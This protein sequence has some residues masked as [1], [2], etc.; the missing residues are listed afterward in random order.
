[1][2]RKLW[3]EIVERTR[4][5][6]FP[7]L[8][9]TRI[10]TLKPILIAAG[11]VLRRGLELLLAPT[12]GRRGLATGPRPRVI[13]RL[14]RDPGVSG[15]RPPAPGGP[16]GSRCAGWGETTARRGGTTPRRN[17]SERGQH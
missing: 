4:F 10:S 9:L 3:K 14:G 1:V 11:G 2:W 8:S 7:S 12:G 17:S 16:L 6:S 5:S 13:R 15:S